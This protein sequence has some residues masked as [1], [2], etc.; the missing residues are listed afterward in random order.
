MAR[1]AVHK[2]GETRAC[3]YL[4]R[5]RF[6]E[7]ADIAATLPAHLVQFERF[8]DCGHG[9]VP[10]APERAMALIRNFILKRWINF[11]AHFLNANRHP[12][13]PKA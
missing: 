7:R 13:E 12:L 11:L 4:E 1:R 6:C 8:A 10:D 3:T 5:V 2:S 9:V